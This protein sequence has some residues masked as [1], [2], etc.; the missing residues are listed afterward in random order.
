M[1]QG[2][3]MASKKPRFKKNLKNLKSQNF[4]LLFFGQILYSFIK[5]SSSSCSIPASR[6]VT[7]ARRDLYIPAIEIRSVPRRL[8]CSGRGFVGVNATCFCYIVTS[9]N[10]DKH[11]DFYLHHV[12]SRYRI[13]GSHTHMTALYHTLNCK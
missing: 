1:Y 4:V 6:L 9:Y 11:A 10:H 13:P 12:L 5:L 8:V 3:K 7:D 2:W